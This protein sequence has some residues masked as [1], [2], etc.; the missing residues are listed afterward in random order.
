MTASLTEMM[1]SAH[2]PYIWPCY[3]LAIVVFAGLAIRATAK[4][5]Y[6]KKRADDDG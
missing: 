2:W 4:L 3:A 5:E 1:A 6:W